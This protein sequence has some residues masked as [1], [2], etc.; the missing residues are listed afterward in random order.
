MQANLDRLVKLQGVDLRL[1]E[2]RRRLASFPERLAGVDATLGNARTKLNA[3][4]ESLANGQKERKKFELDVEQWRERS[5]KYRGQSYE[6]KT[7]E[8]FKALQHEIQHAENEMAQAEDRL[9]ERMVSGEDYDRQVKAA[10]AELKQ[11][12]GVA[13]IERRAIEDER[14]DAEKNLAAIENERTSVVEGI[15]ENLLTEYQ[16]IARRHHG[17]AMSEVRNEACG[18]CGVRIRPHVYQE[19]R[20][21][22][23]EQLFTCE[24]CNRILYAPEP[25]APPLASAQPDAG[26]A[27]AV[28]IRHV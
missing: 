27:T 12:E 19:L 15:P 5:K 9:L 25:T 18:A 3:A 13:A 28:R 26:A 6:V 14:A 10:E 4:R 8:A 11:A 24:T 20:R 22:D 17:V 1:E 16:R 7:N 23:N 2:Q 21:P